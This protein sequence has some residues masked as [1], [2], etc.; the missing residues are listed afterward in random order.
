MKCYYFPNQVLFL[1]FKT[2]V[3]LRF[4]GIYCKQLNNKHIGI[5]NCQV[6]K[7]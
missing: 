5:I 2:G 4:Q 6:N 3:I 7:L 1:F